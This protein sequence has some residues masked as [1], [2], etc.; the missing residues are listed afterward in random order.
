MG[1]S[2]TFSGSPYV[3]VLW[4]RAKNKKPLL[5]HHKGELL[6]FLQSCQLFGRVLDEHS[7]NTTATRVWRRVSGGSPATQA[8]SGAPDATEVRRPAWL[9][10]HTDPAA[11]WRCASRL[12][13]AA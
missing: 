8:A 6:H 2:E 4:K 12:S 13:Q 5:E 7:T 1:I 3:L 9:V 11:P 10:E